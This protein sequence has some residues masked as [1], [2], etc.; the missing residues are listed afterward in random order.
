MYGWK[1]F[2]KNDFMQ[3]TRPTFFLPPPFFVLVLTSSYINQRS[4]KCENKTT[5]NYDPPQTSNT[6]RFLFHSKFKKPFPNKRFLLS[7]FDHLPRDLLFRCVYMHM[8]SLNMY[9]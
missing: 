4:K 7:N 2:M 5:F 6:D 3:I 9:V 1:Y 8:I